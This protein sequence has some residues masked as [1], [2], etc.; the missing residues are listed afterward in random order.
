MAGLELGQRRRPVEVVGEVLLT[1]PHQLDRTALDRRVHGDGD[2]LPDEVDLQTPAVAATEEDWSTEY[3]S[4]DLSAKIVDNIDEAL[5]H[6]A[7]YSTK[8]T[9]SI[10]T[11]SNSNAE[12][13]LADTRDQ[14]TLLRGTWR[15]W[16]YKITPDQRMELRGAY[17]RRRARGRRRRRRHLA[18]HHGLRRARP[19]STTTCCS[20]STGSS[21]A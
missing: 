2:G 16:P 12:R 20:P 19:C 21:P 11:E 14:Y 18:G 6:I 9:E 10:I 3:Y 15:T 1:A 4:L 5:D 8:H 7:K 13:F 17:R